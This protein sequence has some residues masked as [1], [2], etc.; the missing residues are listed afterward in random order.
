LYQAGKFLQTHLPNGSFN[1]NHSLLYSLP[2]FKKDAYLAFSSL[3]DNIIQRGLGQD[4]SLVLGPLYRFLSLRDK[5]IK[6]AGV[7]GD[8]ANGLPDSLEAFTLPGVVAGVIDVL[9]ALQ[10]P[11]LVYLHLFPPHDPY[12]PTNYFG[13]QFQDNWL[14]AEKPIHPMAEGK[15]EHV[16]VQQSRLRYDQFLANW[17]AELKD[18]FIFFETSGL[19][20]KSYLFITSD[21]GE[22]FERGEIGHSTSL[23]YE[24]L[25]RVPLIVR[26]PGQKQRIDVTIPT[27]SLDILPTI[28]HLTNNPRP[29]WAEGELLPALGGTENP[30]RTIYALD[31]RSNSAF[32][33]LSKFSIALTQGD[34]RL[35]YYQYANYTSYEFYDLATDPEEISDLYAS[36]PAALRPLQD[37]LSALLDQIALAAPR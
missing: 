17:D 24:P 29:A 16:K 21:H 13:Q 3:E 23:L 20:E 5:F 27:T 36:R 12:R 1:L 37:E 30:T 35:T 18:L 9:S 22:M 26:Q 25:L 7:S 28:A 31:A 11:S 32:A 33:R 34:Y 8:Y 4:A 19:L 15:F 14:P 10:E 6:T 2:L